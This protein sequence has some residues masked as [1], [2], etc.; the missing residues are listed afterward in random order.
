VQAGSRSHHGHREREP[1]RRELR[2]RAGGNP[3]IGENYGTSP[4]TGA[5]QPSTT[6]IPVTY[7]QGWNLVAGN[8]AVTLSNVTDGP[9]SYVA[10]QGT[11]QS[12]DPSQMQ[13]GVGY[14]VYFSTTT[15]VNIPTTTPTTEASVPLP[16]GQFVMIADSTSGQVT[17]GG[18]DV[19]DVYNAATQTWSQSTTLNPG[20]AAFAY[21]AAGA[22]ASFTS[23]GVTTPAGTS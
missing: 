16:A 18:A 10:S 9:L 22:T 21:S 1:D 5:S 14:W 4:T 7:Q 12:V 23:T 2:H 17:V 3:V 6:G 20:Q 8:T 15:T 11:Y 13:N 19:V